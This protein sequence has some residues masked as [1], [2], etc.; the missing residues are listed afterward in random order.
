MQQ[1]AELGNLS[2]SVGHVVIVS[3]QW[4]MYKAERAE[5][6]LNSSPVGLSRSGAAL[7]AGGAGCLSVSKISLGYVLNQ[8]NRSWETDPSTFDGW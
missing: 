7:V 6:S 4:Y 3:L 1:T 8:T 2:V 5:G